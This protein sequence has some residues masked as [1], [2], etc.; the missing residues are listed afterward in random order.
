MPYAVKNE[1]E[2]DIQMIQLTIQTV[3]A[4]VAAE[5]ASGDPLF[6]TWIFGYVYVITACY[7]RYLD[8]NAV[9]LIL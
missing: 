1:D 4:L 7:I 9:F 6:K 3:I 5:S 2:R 8:K